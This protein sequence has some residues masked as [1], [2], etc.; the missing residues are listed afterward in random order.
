MRC[1]DTLRNALQYTAT[2]CN[3]LQRT[4]THCNALQRTATQCVA[5]CNAL[6]RTATHCNSLNH[7]ASRT[8]LAGCTSRARGGAATHCAML[9]NALQCTATHCHTLQHAAAHQNAR[10]LALNWQDALHVRDE[11]KVLRHIMYAMLCNA[12]Q[13]TA[14]HFHTLQHT[15]AH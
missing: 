10:H 12:L 11:R 2:H 15:A 8:E 3:A 1:C 7:T 4:A 9:C 14:T 6:Q 5:H 13:Y